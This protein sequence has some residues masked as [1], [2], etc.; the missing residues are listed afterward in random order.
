[1]IDL[2]ARQR[3]RAL[4]VRGVNDKMCL[5]G[6]LGAVLLDAKSDGADLDGAVADSVG[7]ER[8]AAGIAK[9]NRVPARTRPTSWP[10]L[11]GHGRCCTGSVRYSLA[12]SN[13]SQHRQPG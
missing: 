5:F 7:W 2:E 9:A 4:N 3:S 6:K 12:R 10:W 1:M 8:L 13:S 11:H